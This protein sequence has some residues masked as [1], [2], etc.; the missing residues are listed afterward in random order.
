MRRGHSPGPFSRLLLVLVFREQKAL[1]V[2]AIGVS[3][4]AMLI[5]D[6]SVAKNLGREDIVPR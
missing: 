1:L 3:D 5:R 6:G 2:L 4:V